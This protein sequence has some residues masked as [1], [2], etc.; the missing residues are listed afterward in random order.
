MAQAISIDF[1]RGSHIRR[2]PV[3]IL[4]ETLSQW[5]REIL[6]KTADSHPETDLLH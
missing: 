2:L 1:N 5:S 3:Q 4:M 6:A